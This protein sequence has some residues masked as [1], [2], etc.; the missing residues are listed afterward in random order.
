MNAITSITPAETRPFKIAVSAIGGQ[1]G[2]VLA[3]WVV[4]L[5][6]ASGFIAQYTSV[7]GVAQRTG[8]TV[9]YLELFPEAAMGP[10]G[11]APKMALMPV[12]GD[13]DIVLAAEL[14]EAGR[15]MLRGFVT[16][17]RTVLVTSSHRVYGILEKQAMGDGTADPS[18]VRKAARKQARAFIEFDMNALAQDANTVIS[19]VLFGALAGADVLPIDAE[20]YRD[21]IRA[22]GRAVEPN[23]AGFQ[24]GYDGAQAALANQDEAA[25]VVADPAQ[26]VLR[27]MATTDAGSELVDRIASNIPVAAHALAFEGV[28]RLADYQDQRY[29]SAYLDRLEQI[30]ALD[31]AHG[32]EARDFVLSEEAARYLALWMAFEDTVRVADLKVRATRFARVRDEVRAD[33]DQIV[34]TT[35]F[36]HPRMQEICDILPNR[37][38]RWTMR[39]DWLHRLLGP[40]FG[41]GRFVNTGSLRGFLMLYGVA[42]L[43]PMRRMSMRHADEVAR[44]D[45]WQDRIARTVSEDYDLAVEIVRCQRLIKGYGDTHARGLANFQRI[46]D[47][48]DNRANTAVD[49][50]H[51]AKLRAAALADESGQALADKIAALSAT[52]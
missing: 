40:V 13:V 2:G 5:A 12:S 28:K 19:A 26:Q 3:E 37:L 32:G 17:E 7:P 23:L 15:A 42:A 9:Y 49:A 21:V 47:T 45:S 29:A 1:G 41:K 51:V 18:A 30:V 52:G 10:D 33:P 20:T 38:G 8:A 48:V 11:A 22:G 16:P 14:T 4:K 35:E 24:A 43:R 31:R 50:E 6:E 27:G 44:I 36:L 34:Y 39:Q 25:V 46:M